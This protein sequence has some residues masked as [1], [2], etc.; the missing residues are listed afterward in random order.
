M[1]DK[2]KKDPRNETPGGDKKPADQVE[3]IVAEVVDEFPAEKPAQPAA[4]EEGP[5]EKKP[6]AQE[7]LSAEK[8]LLKAEKDKY[9][10]LMAEY[11]NYRKR[12][13]KERES[14]FSDVR[15]DTVTKFLPSIR[16][17]TLR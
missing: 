2:K 1:S 15:A 13:V 11:D 14:I 7:L 4:E 8:E 16:S 3:E 12:S 9:L 5:Q 17:R 6:D 10:R